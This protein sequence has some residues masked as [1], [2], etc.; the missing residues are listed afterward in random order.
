MK[1]PTRYAHNSAAAR[2]RLV[3]ALLTADAACRAVISTADSEPWAE[4]KAA[5]KSVGGASLKSAWPLLRRAKESRRAGQSAAEADEVE[6][7]AAF[8][9]AHLAIFGMSS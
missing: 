9:A 1:T 3:D 4:Q 8:T 7:E 6:A 2:T 5:S